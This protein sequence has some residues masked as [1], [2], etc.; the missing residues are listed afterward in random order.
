M[1]AG[2]PAIG[3]ADFP[4]SRTCSK[5]GSTGCAAW[6]PGR[7]SSRGWASRWP[8]SS[9]ASNRRR[10]ARFVEFYTLHDVAQ[11]PGSGRTCSSGRMSRDCAWTKRGIRSSILAVGLYGEVLP[12]QNGAPL[13]L[14]VPWKYRLQEHQVD[15]QDAVRR[16]AAQS[17]AGSVLS[18]GVRVL[19]KR[20]PRGRSSELE[21][22]TGSAAPVVLQVDED[23]TVQRVRRSGRKSVRGDGSSARI[24]ERR[25]TP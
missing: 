9:S 8:T 17:T 7:S 10:R 14:V 15:R 18:A 23:A 5:S 11:F 6:R 25:R 24:L 21:P 1:V 3:N 4:S 22:G 13:R 20:E 12:N 19:R 16:E 2:E